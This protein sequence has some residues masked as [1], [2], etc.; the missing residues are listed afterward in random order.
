MH[1]RR[2]LLSIAT[3]WSLLAISCAEA[4]SVV[5]EK[6]ERLSVGAEV[7]R[8]FCKRAAAEAFPDDLE[9]TEFNAACEGRAAA[10][11]TTPRLSAMLSRRPQIVRA[12]DRVLS[13]DTAVARGEVRAPLEGDELRDFLSS[14]L[15]LYD[16]EQ[17]LP[18]TTRTLSTILGR[19]TDDEDALGKAALDV[20]ARTTGRTGYRPLRLALGVVRPLLEYPR[21]DAFTRSTLDMVATGGSAEAEL[22]AVLRAAAL[23]LATAE[24]TPPAPDSTLALTRDLV[25]SPLPDLEPELKKDPLWLVRRDARGVALPELLDGALPRPF[26][27]TDADGRADIDG[28]GRLLSFTQDRLPAPFKVASEPETQRDAAGRA[29]NVWEPSSELLYRHLDVEGTLLAALAREQRALLTPK[30]P[31]DRTTIDKLA[32]GLPALLGPWAMREYGYGKAR[33]GFRGPDLTNAPVLDLV[34]AAGVLTGMPEMRKAIEVLEAAL[35]DHEGA[36]ARLIDALLEIDRR[37]DA[38]PEAEL[39]G[40]NGPGTPHQFWDDLIAI[41]VRMTQRPGLIE[42]LLRAFLD[43]RTPAQGPILGNWM[44]YKD[45]ITY[46]NAP[47]T[48]PSDINGRV[49]HTYSELV[50]RSQPNVGLNRS[51]FQRTAALVHNLHGQ[52]HCNKPNAK[53]AVHLGPIPLTLPLT[54]PGY[55]PCELFEVP[56][57]VEVYVR[58]VLGRAR[59]DLKPGDLNALGGLC[60]VLD[61]ACLGATQEKE[62][63]IVG[64]DDTPTA[65]ALARFVFSPPNAFVQGISDP[66]TTI[67]GANIQQWEPYALFPLELVDPMAKPYGSPEHPGL[68]FAEAGYPL[69]EAFDD[70]ELRDESGRLVDGYLFGDLMHTLHVHWAA[71]STEPCDGP[72]AETCTQSVDP[73]LPFFSH[74]TN[75]VSYEPLLAEALL[76]VDLLARLHETTNALAN[77]V[78]DGEDGITIMARLFERL[79]SPDP[80]LTYRDGNTRALTNVGEDL[81]YVSPLYLLLD[82]LK[83]IDA[84]FASDEHGMRLPVWREARSELI[85]TLFEIETVGEEKRLKDRLGRAVTLRLMQFLRDRID[86]HAEAGDLSE[87]AASFGP[88]TRDVLEKPV[89]AALVGLLDKTYED[90]AASLEFAGLAKYLF[91]EEGSGFQSSLLATA[92]LLQLFDDANSTAP[93]LHFA[94]EAIAPGVLSAIEQGKPFEVKSGIARTFVELQH[95]VSKLDA[96]DPSTT[97]KLLRNLVADVMEDGR[98][99]L[100]VLLDAAAD[101]ERANPAVPTTTPLDGSDLKSVIESVRAFLSDRDVGLERFYE[102]IQHRNLE[103]D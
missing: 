64:F 33:I 31:G 57:L 42:A 51:L 16:G 58:A 27:D 48:A 68:S 12:L 6:R 40:V 20:L 60:P 39:V 73:S 99:P 37:A 36:S 13:D 66:V 82:A 38:H 56:D 101:I 3:S 14:T 7:F 59:I 9:G 49:Q 84:S 34:H 45:L 11:R 76:D 2:I 75:L 54:G 102:V 96:R 88:R 4:P 71:R 23:E 35:R 85:D 83:G 55:A 78:I 69:F 63:E 70:H 25:L 97:A 77:T 90:E 43:A 53:L 10:P 79:L 61:A 81:G 29:L 18:S 21:L 50:D 30:K 15:P 1:S 22:D 26:L 17:L 87:W 95:A 93:L 91:E 24:D 52:K 100:E 8:V 67:D 103:K 62:S 74:Q 98:T 32:R 5:R 28:F 44:R 94:A 89:V 86:A 47:S 72:P 41:G 80:S 92:D 46:P 19:L 65:E